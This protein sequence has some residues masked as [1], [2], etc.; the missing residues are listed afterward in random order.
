[1]KPLSP[2]A[3]DF[4]SRHEIVQLTR[5]DIEKMNEAMES[6]MC[7]LGKTNAL[8]L[9]LQR[10]LPNQRHLSVVL[11]NGEAV[12]KSG[13]MRVRLGTAATS[14]LISAYAGDRVRPTTI[15][16]TLPA[17]WRPSV[18][19]HPKGFATCSAIRADAAAKTPNSRCIDSGAHHAL[20][21]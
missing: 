10:L 21:Q 9:A 13:N 12:A 20:S 1:M 5:T 11:A 16:V 8:A 15:P 7:D 6:R 17:A 18:P 19:A 4:V 14:W 2:T 3:L